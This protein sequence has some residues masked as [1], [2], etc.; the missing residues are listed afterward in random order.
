[1]NILSSFFLLSFFYPIL[2]LC[3]A[4]T[5]LKLNV[6]NHVIQMKRKK[7]SA[8]KSGICQFRP[9]LNIV[10]QTLQFIYEAKCFTVSTH[11]KTLP[12]KRFL[13]VTR[14]KCLKLFRKVAAQHCLYALAKL[15]NILGKISNIFLMWPNLQTLLVQQISNASPTMRATMFDLERESK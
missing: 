10:V 15:S 6:F 9:S 5:A 4:Y 12:V 8:V 3:V 14:R 7:F 1:M 2:C 13:L 11:H